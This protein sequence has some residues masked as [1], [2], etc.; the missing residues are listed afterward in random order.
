MLYTMHIIWH[1]LNLKW[2]SKNFYKTRTSFMKYDIYIPIFLIVCKC[3]A[4]CAIYNRELVCNFFFT[5]NENY[6]YPDI[7]YAVVL[8]FAD[9]KRSNFLGN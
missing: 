1:T 3:P 5:D 2:M 4:V 8:F 6:I 9:V 7:R